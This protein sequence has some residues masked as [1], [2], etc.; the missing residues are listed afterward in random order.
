MKIITRVLFVLTAGLAALLVLA[1]PAASAVSTV[2]PMVNT[3]TQ[4]YLGF[5]PRGC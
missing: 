5:G 3:A 2:T 1:P 4:V